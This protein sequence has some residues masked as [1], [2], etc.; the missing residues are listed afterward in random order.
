MH[1]HSEIFLSTCPAPH[2][3]MYNHHVYAHDY[4]VEKLELAV[5]C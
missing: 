2:I 5:K 3:Y 4:T 1:G